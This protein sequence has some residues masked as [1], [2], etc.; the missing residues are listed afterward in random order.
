MRL[1]IIG[2][3]LTVSISVVGQNLPVQT[4]GSDQ[5]PCIIFLHGGPGYNAVPF[6][7]LT[8][9][10]LAAAGFY[11]LSY[12]RRGEGRNEG[13]TAEYDFDQTVSDLDSIRKANNLERWI[14]LGHSF[15]GVI[16]A[17]YATAHPGAVSA[18]VLV[19]APVSM[20]ATLRTI[21]T[22]SKAIYEANN[23]A[24]NLNYIG[25]LEK[26]DTTSLPYSTYL[27]AHAM[28]NG[29]YRVKAPTEEAKKLYQ[30]FST[31]ELLREYGS[32][33]GYAA[34]AGFWASERYTSLSIGEQI[35]R[36]RGE[37][38]PV[39][40]VYGADDGLYDLAQIE[41]VSQLL[42]EDRVKVVERASH[43]VFVDQRAAFIED[44]QDWLF[45]L[46]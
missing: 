7:R 36:L 17:E 39:Y 20:Q 12:D 21:L 5:D 27:F 2:F 30:T 10:S 38:M 29:F 4:F 42:G 37:G 14:L 41:Q 25:M 13:L 15:G 8:A 26:M 35:G 32:K 19:S 43:N 16:A 9:D 18:V 3:L 44:L 34:P 31:D 23:D 40:A 22:R 45:R 28:Q 46:E 1:L 6:E 24:V 33:S 11:V